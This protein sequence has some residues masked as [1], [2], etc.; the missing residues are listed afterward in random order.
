MNKHT[1]GPWYQWRN[2]TRF[3]ISSAT[4]DNI[5]MVSTGKTNQEANSYLIAAAPD[6]LEALKEIIKE[7]HN[8]PEGLEEACLGV[9]IIK[10]RKAIS[11]ADGN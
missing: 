7:A 1:A 10:A 2:K 6:M 11:K 4:G 3:H 8:C 5:A 9:I